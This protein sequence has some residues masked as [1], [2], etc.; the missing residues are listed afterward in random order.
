MYYLKNPQGICSTCD[1]KNSCDLLNLNAKKG[2]TV[3]ECNEFSD[4]VS[5]RLPYSEKSKEMPT[6]S[7][8]IFAP[9][10]AKEPGLCQDCE[11]RGTCTMERPE[12]GVWHCEEYQ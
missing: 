11:N 6:V 1:H 3:H 9:V 5:S 12:T 10:V 2:R 4:N 8:E 7:P